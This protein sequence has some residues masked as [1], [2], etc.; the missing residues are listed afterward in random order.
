MKTKPVPLA[1][2]K[3]LSLN[4]YIAVLE[5]EIRR[6]T[7]ENEHKLKMINDLI[8]ELSKQEYHQPTPKRKQ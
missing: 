4:E 8:V 1:Q 3:G 5:K 7:M 6:L 2:E